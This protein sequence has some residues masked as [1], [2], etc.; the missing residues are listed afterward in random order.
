MLMSWVFPAVSSG[1]HRPPQASAVPDSL[2][3]Q[4]PRERPGP[5]AKAPLSA[6]CQ[7]IRLDVRR[8]DRGHPLPGADPGLPGQSPEDAVPHALPSPPVEPVL[9]RGAGAVD[10]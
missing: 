4:P 8:L 9:D 5:C 1:T 3:V 2:L 7:A 6:R 10:R